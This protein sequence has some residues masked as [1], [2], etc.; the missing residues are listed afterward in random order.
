MKP[1]GQAKDALSNSA[2]PARIHAHLQ[3]TKID[4][5]NE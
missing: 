3:S 4:P 2:A 5:L 1:T